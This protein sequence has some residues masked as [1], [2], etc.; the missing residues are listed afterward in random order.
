M[1]KYINEQDNLTETNKEL[2]KELSKK[3]I[4]KLVISSVGN[5]ISTGFSICNSSAPLLKR[6]NTLK[7]CADNED[8]DLE[9]HQFSR[10]ENN[11]DEHILNAFNKNKLES[12]FNKE[13]RRDYEMYI[14]R[15]D[16]LLS[17]TEIDYYY[18]ETLEDDKGMEDVLFESEPDT[19]NFVIYNGGTG[20]LLDN[21]TRRGKYLLNGIPKDIGSIEAIL[22]KIQFNN[23][24][25]YGKTQVYLCGAPRIALPFSSSL[26][27]NTRLKKI[28]DR[29]A[30]VTYIPNFPR[31]IFY[32]K[33]GSP[34]PIP[35]PHYNENEYRHLLNETEK[36][37]IENYIIKECII[38]IDRVFNRTSQE[39][40]MNHV[41]SKKYG[42]KF[43]LDILDYYKAMVKKFDCDDNRFIYEVRDYLLERYPYD[44]Y[45]LDYNSIKN[46]SLKLTR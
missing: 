42:K 1:E 41:D 26:A 11:S 31:K 45:Y 3:R 16:A 20:S 44:F 22:S 6:N 46:E 2:M 34:I 40:E 30:N 4:K 37:M 19:A 35:D 13:N 38:E 21:V 25:N 27:I 33:N 39:I 14:K 24:E 12:E 43:I 36:R 32:Q 28:A 17:P 15:N 9:L 8:I 23:R 29:Y 18:P 5:S 10:G 7:Q